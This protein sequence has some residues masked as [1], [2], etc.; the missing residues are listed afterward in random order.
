MSCLHLSNHRS[1][2]QSIKYASEYRW[3]VKWQ[4]KE[5]VLGRR[6]DKVSDKYLEIPGIMRD[7]RG[8]TKK[9]GGGVWANPD[10]ASH[11]WFPKPIRT[12]NKKQTDVAKTAVQRCQSYF[13]PVRDRGVDVLGVCPMFYQLNEIL[14]GKPDVDPPAGS[15]GESFSA[16]G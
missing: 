8:G 10:W 1:E 3:K 6:R 15:V 13:R 7:V 9:K 4:A 12:S 11:D 16:S 5:N 2:T 14:G